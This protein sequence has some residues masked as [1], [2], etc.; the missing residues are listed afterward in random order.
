MHCDYPTRAE[1]EADRV[2]LEEARRA[3]AERGPAPVTAHDF[4]DVDNAVH[5]RERNNPEAD[6]TAIEEDEPHAL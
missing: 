5:V 4:G 2:T 1:A 3:I 6:P